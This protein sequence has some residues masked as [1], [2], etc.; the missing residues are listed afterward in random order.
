MSAPSIATKYG[1]SQTEI[2]AIKGVIAYYPATGAS[3]EERLAGK[4]VKNDEWL[5]ANGIPGVGFSKEALGESHRFIAETSR[6]T[7]RCARSLLCGL[8]VRVRPRR[9]K[10]AAR[11]GPQAGRSLNVGQANDH[12]HLRVRHPRGGGGR[13]C[14]Q[15]QIGWKRCRID[16]D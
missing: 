6:L 7:L 16:A 12:H 3:T 10:R 2:D 13:L 11:A 14:K 5:V 9:T 4:N 8:F 15:A 1:L